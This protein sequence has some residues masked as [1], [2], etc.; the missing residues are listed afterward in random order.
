[1]NSSWM[2]FAAEVVAQY[3]RGLRQNRHHSWR[4]AQR[5]QGHF[6]Q[7]TPRRTPYRSD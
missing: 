5:S 1:M 7:S 3:Q 4:G 2:E 6:A